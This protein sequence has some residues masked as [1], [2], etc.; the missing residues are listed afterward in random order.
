VIASKGLILAAVVVAVGAGAAGYWFLGGRGGTPAIATQVATSGGAKPVAQQG[1]WMPE[2]L[3]DDMIL[4]SP[5]AK[6]TIVEYASLTC[7]HC[8]RFHKETLPKIK[9]EF[10]DTG[11]VRLVYRDFPFDEASLRA[12][13]MARCAGK[14]RFFGF[15]DA[16]FSTQESWANPNSWKTSLAR[17]GKL[18]GMS[19]E[20]F[21]K[22][23][24][25][26][27]VED[28]IL[29]RRLEGQKFGVDSTPTFF[30]NGEKVS[31]AYP[32]DH[33]AEIIKRKSPAS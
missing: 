22:C 11:K 9:S 31:G 15:L 29:A 18:G 16:L 2:I 14:E 24:V 25:D 12:A 19:Q 7:S 1:A 3:A 4:G 20:S 32:F 8:A 33:F 17:I 30:V 6:V 13:M 26:K 27:S 10:V 21:D 5:D 23:L 28:G